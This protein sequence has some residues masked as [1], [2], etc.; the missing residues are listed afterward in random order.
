MKRLYIGET[1]ITKSYVGN[2]LLGTLEIPSAQPAIKNIQ[3]AVNPSA[4]IS[5]DVVSFGSAFGGNQSVASF[6][7]GDTGF[8]VTDFEVII[9]LMISADAVTDSG[10]LNLLT[11]GESQNGFRTSIFMEDNLWKISTE[12]SLIT[13]PTATKLLFKLHSLESGLN[14]AV[15]VDNGSTWTEYGPRFATISLQGETSLRILSSCALD[16]GSISLYAKEITATSKGNRYT[17]SF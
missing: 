11:K 1:P 14:C 2:S 12:P 5:G 3:L 7:I 13:L 4:I 9:P 10:I 6:A 15:S 17:F 8:D 16:T